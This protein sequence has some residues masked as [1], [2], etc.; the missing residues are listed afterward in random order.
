MQRTVLADRFTVMAIAV[1]A[2]AGVNIS[3][4]IVG[5]CGMAALVGTKCTLI[6]ST[7]ITLATQLPIWKYNIIVTAG[8]TA[9]WIVALVCLGLLRAWRTA[10]PTVR[11][12]LW[13][14][15]CVNL[16]LPATYIAVAPII[17]Y[18]DSYILIHDLPGQLFW[19]S[20]LV[21]VG[22]ALCWLSFRLCRNELSRLIGFGGRAARSIA[23]ELVVPAYIVGGVVTVT[24]GLFSQ[25]EFKWAQL[26][27]AGGTF[28]LTVWLLLLPLSIPEEQPSVERPFMIPRSIGWIVAGALIGLIFIGALRPGIPL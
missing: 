16:F 12:F 4:E 7:N 19:R 25:L 10:R 20:A 23:W 26:Q 17:E 8:S 2:Y 9:N 21:L 11:Y 6:S 28:G 15:M 3:H 24:S 13:L 14:A 18:G 1:I 22:G 5:H 27:A